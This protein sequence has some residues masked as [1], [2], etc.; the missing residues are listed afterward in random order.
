MAL[1]VGFLVGVPVP[2]LATAA[3]GIRVTDVLGAVPV[4]VGFIVPATV[5][6]GFV[7]IMLV[8]VLEAATL[9]AEVTD[10]EGLDVVGTAPVAAGETVGL[11]DGEPTT[12]T[13]PS[14]RRMAL[15]MARRPIVRGKSCM[16]LVVLHEVV[17]YK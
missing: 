2:V 12:A 15:E 17:L 16:F 3:L 14:E 6:G 8:P 7:A 11:R 10:I 13:W 9:G 1:L 5:V 4:V